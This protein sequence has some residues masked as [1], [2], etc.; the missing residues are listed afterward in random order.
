MKVLRKGSGTTCEFSRDDR[1]LTV[2]LTTSQIVH[3]EVSKNVGTTRSMLNEIF[4]LIVLDETSVYTDYTR[5]E[6]LGCDGN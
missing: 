6:T 5:A 4:D 1:K 3:S 2:T